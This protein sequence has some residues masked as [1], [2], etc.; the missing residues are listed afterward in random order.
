MEISKEDTLILKG[1]SIL[2]LLFHHMFYDSEN[3]II[4]LIARNLKI[5]V[6]MFLVLSGYGL[7]KS[8]IKNQNSLIKFIGKKLF[9]LLTTY[10]FIFVFSILFGTLFNYRSLEEAYKT[11]K[12]FK[13]IKE[14]FCLHE[15]TFGHGYNATWWFMSLIVLLYLSFPLFYT[16]VKN[17]KKIIIYLF[18]IFS[19]IVL[20]FNRERFFINKIVT[21]TY[22]FSYIVC[23]II[24]IYNAL[25]ERKKV[26]NNFMGLMII[27]LLFYIRENYLPYSFKIKDILFYFESTSIDFLICYYI[28]LLSKESF[29]KDNKGLIVLGTYSYEI[30]LTHSFLFYYYF[31]KYVNISK[32]FFIN[33]LWFIIFSLIVGVFFQKLILYIKGVINL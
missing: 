25:Y 3:K 29:L 26:M 27:L 23:F 21:I 30:F 5:C 9:K 2:M 6:A 31:P 7:T 1:I 17:Y 19:I 20:N 15:F 16:F 28:I 24:G 32:Y 4:F 18:I 10:W 22:C 33:Y 13:L 11:D 12:Y 8:Y 14:F